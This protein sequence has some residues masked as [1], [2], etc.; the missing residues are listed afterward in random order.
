MKAAGVQE[1]DGAAIAIAV[2]DGSCVCVNKAQILDLRM[3]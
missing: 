3:S 2:A 1:E